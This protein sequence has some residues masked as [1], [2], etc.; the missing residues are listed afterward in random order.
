[1]DALPIACGGFLLAVL[2]FDLMF[3]VQV[4]GHRN[5][6]LPEDVLSSIADYYRRVT[7]DA[8]PMG[9]AVGGAMLLGLVTVIAQLLAGS[10]ARW[11]SILSL[12]LAVPPIALAARRV[13]PNAMR[14]A[15]RADPVGVQSALARQIFRDH[16]FCLAAIG[17]FLLVQLLARS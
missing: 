6:D 17:A 10:P 11:V 4:L 1:M 13:V 2:W 14:L 9:H 15:R 7:I 12:A 16:V 3:D 5:G 8:R